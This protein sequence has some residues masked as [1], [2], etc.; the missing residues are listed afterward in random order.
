MATSATERIFGRVLRPFAK[1]EPGE[2]V[3]A[4]VLTFTVFLLLTAYYFLKTA[5]EPLILLHGGAEVKAYAAAGQSILLVGV[6]RAYSALARRVGRMR[7]IASI[8]LFFVANLVV[9]ALLAQA[10]A[11]IGVPFYLWVGIFNVTVIAQF[12]SFAADIYSPEQGKRIFAIIG[13]GSS[14]GAVAGARIAKSLVVLGPQGLMA[15]AAVVL[16]V[17]VLLLGWV[18]GRSGSPARAKGEP[19]HEQPLVDARTFQ[20][21]L[22]DRYLLLVGLL[23]FV[24]NWVNTNGEYVLDRTLLAAVGDAA[25]QGIDPNQFVGAFKAQYFEWVNILGMALQLFAV[26]RILDKLG[27]RN[28]LFFLPTVA[29]MSYTTMLFFPLLALIRIG[30]VMEN[31][32][33]YSIQNTSRQ[34]LFLVTSRVEKFVGKTVVDTLIVRIGDV[35]SAIMVYAGTLMAL[36]TKAFAALNIG[37]ICVWIVTVFA[38]GREHARRSAEGAERIEQEPA[39]S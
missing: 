20:L 28:A 14:A 29:L 12:W 19:S 5:R 39:P 36:P 15:G 1:I 33:D 22:H 16:V 6:V 21:L 25:A 37:L 31:G 11:S 18:E 26:S 38:I 32:I 17:C 7:L 9:F 3:V 10:N 23:T 4:V 24:L 8:Y 30:K 2:A 13:V 35:F 27:V 34:A